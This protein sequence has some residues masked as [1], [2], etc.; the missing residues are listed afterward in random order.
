MG[1]HAVK[2]S[3]TLLAMLLMGASAQG[4]DLPEAK[5]LPAAAAP[6]S[7]PID[8]AF[9]ARLQS[10]YVFR[11]ISQSD[12]EPSLQGYGELR[13]F[14]NFLYAGVAF[15]TVDLPT[16]PDAEIDLTVG[17]RPTLGPISFDLGVIG[18]WYPGERRLFDITGTSYFTVANTDYVELAGKASYS[19]NDQFSVGANVFHAW[20]WLGSGATGTYAS[21]TAKYNLPF[22]EGLSL[23]GE[24]GHYWLG[25]T[26]VQTGS[27]RLP[28]Y[29]YWNAG[30]SYTYKLLT[31]DLRYHDTNL[32]R[33]DCY[34]LTTDPAGIASGTS[35][36]PW[37]GAAFVA[38]LAVDITASQVG[39]F[40]PSR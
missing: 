3:T 23:S 21:V 33:R 30:L 7:V 15:A 19:F 14:D 40:A 26:S 1:L 20:D 9:G 17:I 29:T 32:S 34:T 35:R 5:T 4:A 27:V 8:F 22:V 25:T 16:R 24:L 18:Y 6:A 28:D 12:R 11:G 2:R 36:S 37:C 10:D 39:I 13:L 31:L 38:S